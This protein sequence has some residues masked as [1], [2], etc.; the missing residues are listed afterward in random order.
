V[1]QDASEFC[2]EADVRWTGC[3]HADFSSVGSADAG[4]SLPG[5]ILPEEDKQAIETKPR[6]IT[7][8]G[9]Q[10]IEAVIKQK[11]TG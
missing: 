1:A 3:W 7:N 10:T 8:E 5:P 4:R 11:E 2:R 9:K 6:E